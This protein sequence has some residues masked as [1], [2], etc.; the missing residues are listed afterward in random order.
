MHAQTGIGDAVVRKLERTT[1]L[2]EA[3]RDAIRR[4]RHRSGQ[5][6]AG[7][8]LVREGDPLAECPILVDGFTCRHKGARGGG[9]QI[10]SFQVPGD[11]LDLQHIFF[12]RADHNLQAIT[13][14]KLAWVRYDDLR[15]LIRERPAIAE[16]LWRETLVEASIFREWVLNVGRRDAMT[17]VAHMLCEF[18]A[19]CEGAGVQVPERFRLPMTQE[20]IADATGLTPVHVNRTLRALRDEGVIAGTGKH[21]EVADW[22]RMRAVGDF[23]PDYL[24]QAA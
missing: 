21:I 22:A 24:H 15:A 4:L 6:P 3:D 9:R 11:I 14:V 10:V 18:V 1:R 5:A 16:A 8:Y 12:A 19:Q 13:P 20:D 7:S 17:R 23:R 2:D